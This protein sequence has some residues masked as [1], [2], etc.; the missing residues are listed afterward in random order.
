VPD[1]LPF[2]LRRRL[3]EWCVTELDAVASLRG[4]ALAASVRMLDSGRPAMLGAVLAQPLRTG[5]IG[6]QWRFS[7]APPRRSG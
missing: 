5:E 2:E 3:V 6:V 1:D 4:S 7:M